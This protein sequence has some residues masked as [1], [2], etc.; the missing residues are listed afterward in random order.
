MKVLVTGTD[1]YIGVLLAPMLANRGHEVIGLDAGFYLD[2]W[3]SDR[4]ATSA[5]RIQKDIRR[6]TAEDVR[7]CDAVV[8]LAE[9]SNDP[10]GE[11]DPELTYDINYRGSVH[12]ATVCK[13]AG[14]PRFV[15]SS[16]CSV[17]GAG[18]DHL[19]TEESETCPQTVYARCKI[20]VEQALLSMADDTFSPVILRNATAFGPSPRMR[21]DIVLNNLAGWAWTVG[22]IKMTSDGTPWRPL[23]HVLDICE[24]AACALEA[25]CEPVH[26]QIFNVGT[27]AQ[28]YRVREIAEIVAATFPGCALTLG[29]SGGDTRSYRVSFD[30]IHTR[31]PGFICARDA[32]LGA[33]QVRDLF[34][35]VQL[36]I[37]LFE[38]RAFTRLR[39][40]EH[41]LS[42]QRVSPELFWQ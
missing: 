41:L 37:E 11:H 24:A 23:V 25:P 27:A 29:E 26:G 10:L 8:H 34:E 19:R 9:L 17:Y 39:Q 31:L 18:S 42:T 16:S 1:G 5:T 2:G 15:Y 12:L 6:I 33:Q 4:E 30:K 22:E 20:L 3:L 13:A 32:A 14:I 28:N 40:L 38:F 35:R 21:F 36:S 7:G